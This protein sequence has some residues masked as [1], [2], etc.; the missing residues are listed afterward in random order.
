MGE[1]S[2][3]VEASLFPLSLVLGTQVLMRL[4]LFKPYL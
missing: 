3:I 4:F 1:V 2:F